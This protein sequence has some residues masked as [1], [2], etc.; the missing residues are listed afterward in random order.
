M[1]LDLNDLNSVREFA[2]AFNQKY[3]KLDT[4]MLNA[5]IM[6]LPDRQET[7]QGHEKQFGVN[8]LGHFLLT[9]LLMMKVNASQEGRII[10]LSSLAH[11]KGKIKFDDID[12]TAS[13]AGWEAYEMSKLANVYFTRSLA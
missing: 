3:D 6:A 13:Y 7:A 8:H 4:L 9:K 5:G 2:I 10:V 1:R 11:T 12:H